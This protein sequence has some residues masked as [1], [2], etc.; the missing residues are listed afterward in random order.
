MTDLKEWL[1]PAQIEIKKYLKGKTT[2]FISQSIDKVNETANEKYFVLNTET[3][4]IEQVLV[5]YI[6]KTETQKGFKVDA[7][8]TLTVL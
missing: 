4:T 1:F 8:E 5:F 6:V 2:K 3:N 7:C